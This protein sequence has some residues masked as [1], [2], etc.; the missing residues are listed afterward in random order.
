VKLVIPYDYEYA[1]SF[2]DGVARVRK[3]GL[4]GCI[5]V[6]GKWI[7]QATYNAIDHVAADFLV[8]ETDS[9]KGLADVSGNIF[10]YPVWDKIAPVS[11]AIFRVERNSKFAYYNVRT[12]QFQ[13]KEKDFVL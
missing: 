2:T 4:V 11:G 9:G 7:L 12:R 1:W 10:L 13:W 3:D 5:D 8:L 6:R